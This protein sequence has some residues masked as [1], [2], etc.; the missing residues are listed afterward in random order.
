MRA[1]S[2]ARAVPPQQRSRDEKTCQLGLLLCQ[3]SWSC[4][5]GRTYFG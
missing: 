1:A 5:F 3:F 4:V 2:T